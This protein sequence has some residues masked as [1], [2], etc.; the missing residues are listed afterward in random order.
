[1]HNENDSQHI[2][3]DINRLRQ[4][5]RVIDFPESKK[6]NL[7]KRKSDKIEK[8]EIL[9]R[10]LGFNIRINWTTRVGKYEEKITKN[11]ML[12][13]ELSSKSE[14]ELL[15]TKTIQDKLRTTKKVD[16]LPDLTKP[17]GEKA[18]KVVKKRRK[19]IASGVNPRNLKARNLVLNQN[20]EPVNIWLA[21]ALT[22]GNPHTCGNFQK[23]WSFKS[24][25]WHCNP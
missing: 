11:R 8:V 1:M 6:N 17:Y 16:I 23:K 22:V 14:A 15:A 12:T 18:T 13:V 7:Y 19:L 5:I 4:S 2:T 9:A 10:D 3:T 24:V 20:E 21:S 25:H